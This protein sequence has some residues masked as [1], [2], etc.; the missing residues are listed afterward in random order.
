MIHLLEG[1]ALRCVPGLHAVL[2]GGELRIVGTR[3]RS[4]DSLVRIILL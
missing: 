3:I 4:D 1:V 2:G